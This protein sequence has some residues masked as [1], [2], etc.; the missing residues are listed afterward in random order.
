MFSCVSINNEFF[1]TLHHNLDRNSGCPALIWG[2]RFL[3]YYF[4]KLFKKS[5][6]DILKEPLWEADVLAMDE[7][8]K[9]F[10]RLR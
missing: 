7:S 6:F 2:G 5:F 9:C 10:C 8:I 1:V 4:V 3:L